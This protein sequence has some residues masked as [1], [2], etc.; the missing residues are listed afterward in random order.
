MKSERKKYV[1]NDG[2]VILEFIYRRSQE[3]GEDDS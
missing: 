1:L 3:Q 2:D